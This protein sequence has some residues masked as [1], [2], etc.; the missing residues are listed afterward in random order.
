MRPTDSDGK[1]G[2]PVPREAASAVVLRTAATGGLEVLLVRRGRPPLAGVWSLPGGKLEPGETAEQAVLREVR[3][4]TGLAVRLRGRL[5]QHGVEAPDGTGWRIAVYLAAA[6]AG[7]P[8]AGDDA[9][10]AAFVPLAR[11]ASLTLTR[12]AA[13]LILAGARRFDDKDG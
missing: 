1:S 7:D 12:G 4:E 8:A 10:D 11:L 9:A 3:E 6:D 13:D 2:C 5:G